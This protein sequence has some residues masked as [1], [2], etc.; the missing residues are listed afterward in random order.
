MSTQIPPFGWPVPE[1]TD[2]LADGAAAIRQLATALAR[3]AAAAVTPVS[4]W[5]DGAGVEL[6]RFGGLVVAAF[7]MQRGTTVSV[8]GGWT[9]ATIPA[10]FRPAATIMGTLSTS[11][12]TGLAT[13]P[14]TISVGST[15]GNV[16]IGSRIENTRALRG[17][18]TWP[19]VEPWP[20]G[21]T[22]T[23]PA[24]PMPEL[25]DDEPTARPA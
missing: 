11:W 14:A 16:T 1:D 17:S 3:V 12:G 13:V 25:L 19:C 23:V 4:P 20:A 5:T 2:P 6:A 7:T 15:T 8:D 18:M 22:L 9:V 24:A 21:G 10:G